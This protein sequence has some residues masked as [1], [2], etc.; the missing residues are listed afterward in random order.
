[1]ARS[2]F[3]N[4]FSAMNF[5][6]L[7]CTIA[8]VRSMPKPTAPTGSP[9]FPLAHPK[10]PPPPVPSKKKPVPVTKVQPNSFEMI[11]AIN[12]NRNRH[13]MQTN[14]KFYHMLYWSTPFNLATIY[15]HLLFHSFRYRKPGG[16]NEIDL[17][18]ECYHNIASIDEKWSLSK[19]V[20]CTP[21]KWATR[22]VQA[23]IGR[24]NAQRRGQV[25]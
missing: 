13:L 19:T 14:G 20:W 23:I 2:W 17:C 25:G 5:Q 6:K 8:V 24:A 1:M 7:K 9:K 11:S 16:G 22:F 3:R 12:D 18:S 4:I 21:W 10:T 15:T